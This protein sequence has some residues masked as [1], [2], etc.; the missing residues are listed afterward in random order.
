MM[1]QSN[2]CM[3]HDTISDQRVFLGDHVLIGV[4]PFNSY[5]SQENLEKII[6]WGLNNFKNIH[7]FL[8]DEIYTYTFLAL[9]Y[10]IERAKKKTRRQDC[11]LKN[12]VTK[13]LI[14]NGIVESDID[15]KIILLSELNL[16]KDYLEMYNICLNLFE[17]NKF[18]REGCLSASTWI[19]NGKGI[20]NL[21]LNEEIVD[22]AVKYFLAELPLFLN[23]PKILKIS[24]S[25]FMYNNIPEFLKNIYEQKIFIS[26]K[27]GFLKMMLNC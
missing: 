1:P 18:F 23:T 5:F 12:K 6:L 24:S 2:Q 11:Y 26:P 13:A 15:K 10:S 22:I 4:S 16:N 8:P 9:G 14:N 3:S 27:Q 20:S 7:I 25:I 17:N 21:S 19:L